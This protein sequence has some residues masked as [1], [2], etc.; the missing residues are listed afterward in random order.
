MHLIAVEA[1]NEVN[2]PSVAYTYINEIRK[3]ARFNRIVAAA[4]QRSYMDGTEMRAF[5]G[6][7]CLV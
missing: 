5:P 7:K 3:R 6:R 2:G 4:V 1:E